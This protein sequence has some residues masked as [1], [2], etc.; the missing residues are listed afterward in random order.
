MAKLSAEALRQ[1]QDRTL[2]R[3]NQVK[4]HFEGTKGTGRFQGKVAIL[5][6]V[7]SEKGIG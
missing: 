6:G 5:T 4:T 3:L 7:G 1:A 2:S